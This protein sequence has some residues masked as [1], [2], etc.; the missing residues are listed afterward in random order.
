MSLFRKSEVEQS[1][2]S[3]NSEELDQL[4]VRIHNAALPDYVLDT[5]Q[6]EFRRLEKSE[7]AVAEYGIGL[8]YLEFLLD[9]PWHR[10]S[11]DN[12]D[13]AAAA[14]KLNAGH[15][16]LEMVKDR[17]LDHLAANIMVRRGQPKILVVDDEQIAR[18]NISHILLEDG[19]RVETAASSEKGLELFKDIDFDIVITDLKME[20]MDGLELL[21]TWKR[22]SPQTDFIVITG[23]ATVETAVDALK[24]GAYEYLAKPLNLKRLREIVTQLMERRTQA[25]AM[26]GPI[27]C[28]TGPPGTGKTSIGKA[29]AAALDRTFVR[30]SMAGLRDE[31]ELRGHRRTYVGAMPGRILSEL[32][33][34]QVNNPVFM[35]DEIDKVGQDFKG[36]PASVL[37]EIL[38]PEQNQSFL[39]YY[40]DIPFDL[41]KILF[42]T[43]S[44]M[45]ER[46]PRPLQ[47]RMEVIRF[48]SYTLSE[49]RQISQKHLF[50]KQAEA[51]G[52]KVRDVS[53]S[54]EAIDRIILDYTREAGVR[55]LE[56]K[57]GGLCRRLV[58]LTLQDAR[59]L[60]TVINPNDLQELMGRPVFADWNQARP[61]SPGF[62]SGLVWS[63]TGGHVIYVET[64]IMRGNGKLS[65][66]GSLGRVLRE[67]AQTALSYIRSK[68]QDLEIER[69]FFAES[70]IHVHIPAG[71]IPKDGPSAGITIAAALASLLTGKPVCKDLAMTGEITLGGHVLPIS[72]IRE[73][74]LAAQQAGLKRV[75]LPSANQHDVEEL[76]E[77]I[78]QAVH[79]IFVQ[80]LRQAIDISL[81]SG[82]YD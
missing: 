29:I 70:D 30:L 43:T 22:F 79:P 77:E 53:I 67:S 41:S 4:R 8:N 32:R 25:Q 47:D 80:D 1:G 45:V 63:E 5:A 23:Y 74:L 18:E 42:I 61:Q 69:D 49:K 6:K 36:D 52:L 35:L 72:G 31:A 62:A 54:S 71:S 27:I 24:E 78:R 26:R 19:Y 82:E 15:Q 39:D 40:L 66:T 9:L 13:L 60:P 14:E 7:P 34:I 68:A 16:G 48:S 3:G 17:V 46:L 44:N 59:S 50:A 28:F 10:S 64:A 38:D 81:N 73:K 21:R 57:L 65:M 58:R 11:R 56:R 37:L 2:A 76:A 55:D 75:L 33:R 20:G 12:L 51:A